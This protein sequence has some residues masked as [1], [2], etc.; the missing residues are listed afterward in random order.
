VRK[1][2]GQSTAAVC[3]LPAG[4]SV[5]GLWD[6]SGNGWEWTQDPSQPQARERGGSDRDHERPPASLASAELHRRF[7][8]WGELGFRCVR[9][10][11]RVA[12]WGHR[13]N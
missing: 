13:I 12:D 6:M 2:T 5:S 3:S 4:S 1:D 8:A 9:P 10:E 11:V 7:V